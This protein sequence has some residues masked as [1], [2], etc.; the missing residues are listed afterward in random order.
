MTKHVD[1]GLF[2]PYTR[3]MAK[4]RRKRII[5]DFLVDGAYTSRTGTM[6]RIIIPFLEEH[7]LEYNIS[8]R[9]ATG[10]DY[11]ALTIDGYTSRTGLMVLDTLGL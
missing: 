7:K 4:A 1:Y 5:R 6:L 10:L 2:L 11:W 9:R 3:V 8:R